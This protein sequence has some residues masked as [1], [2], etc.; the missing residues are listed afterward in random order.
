[1]S[2]STLTRP[3]R[4]GFLGTAVALSGV[5]PLAPSLWTLSSTAVEAAAPA[6]P[7]APAFR[8]RSL[9]PDEA[10]FT[11]AM[12]N[13]LCPADALT[14]DG[15]TCGLAQFVDR[16]LAGDFGRRCAQGA[17]EHGGA[18]PRAGWP[19]T[20]EQFFK[21]GVAAANTACE[22]RFGVRFDRL[23][24]SDAARFLHEIGAGRITDADL[25]L[26]AWLNDVV[27]PVLVEACFAG[28]IYDGYNNKVFWKLFG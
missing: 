28:P 17:W 20:Q 11:E 9:T 23:A 22:K 10:S 7:A 19:L 5:A 4:R 2:E 1:M 13:V 25:P 18:G 14:P 27:D 21:A 16:H 24:A 6:L 12:V 26:S 8:Y 15:V 3:T